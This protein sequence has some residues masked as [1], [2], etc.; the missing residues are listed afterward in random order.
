ML[1]KVAILNHWGV[2]PVLLEVHGVLTVSF[3]DLSCAHR[4]ISNIHLSKVLVI[5]LRDSQHQSGVKMLLINLVPVDVMGEIS[6]DLSQHFL[7][8]D[9]VV[10]V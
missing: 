7:L 1:L 6:T 9:H 4:G 5:V 2:L 10:E 3:G 8:A